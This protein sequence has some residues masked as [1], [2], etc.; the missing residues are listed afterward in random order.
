MEL[1]ISEAPA[2]IRYSGGDNVAC[3]LYHAFQD[4][5]HRAFFVNGKTFAPSLSPSR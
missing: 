4:L 5:I 1:M 3:S 2:D